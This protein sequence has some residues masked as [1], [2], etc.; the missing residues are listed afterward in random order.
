[1][2]RVQC[3]ANGWSCSTEV[4]LGD[5]YIKLAAIRHEGGVACG[6]RRREHL[7]DWWDHFQWSVFRPVISGGHGKSPLS[8]DICEESV[9]SSHRTLSTLIGRP[10]RGASYSSR[11]A[12]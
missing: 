10:P 11:M 3:R 5:A 8:S 6:E 7:Q 9:Q 1:M 4:A 12:I 2:V